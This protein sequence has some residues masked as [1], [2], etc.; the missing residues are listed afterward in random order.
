MLFHDRLEAAGLLAERLAPYRGT[1]P[2]VLGLPRGGVLMAREI[3]E[4]LG[5][6]LDV[7]LAR[8][9]RAPERRELAV[10]AVAEN[11]STVLLP[12]KLPR[13]YIEA[14]REEA[15]A[16]LRA[17]RAVYTPGRGPFDASGRVVIVVDDGLAGGA[18]LEAALR[19]LEDA[20][21]RVVAT[22]VAP[23]GTL[24]RLR[25]L[26]EEVVCLAVP[27]YFGSASRFFVDFPDVP[28]TELVD[29]LRA[30]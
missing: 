23:E 1:F 30:I 19:A 18:P 4:A 6:E 17:Q 12:R 9:L 11:G 5:G 29:A 10:G 22:A 14:E 25:G 26:A 13:S 28:E 20:E 15:L 27:A 2:L 16:A 7:V 24:D 8:K 3:A 21:R